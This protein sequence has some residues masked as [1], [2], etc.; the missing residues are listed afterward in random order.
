MYHAEV[1]LMALKIEHEL[2]RRELLARSRMLWEH[3]AEPARSTGAQLG[4]LSCGW[5]EVN[6]ALRC[7]WRWSRLPPCA[8]AP[9]VAA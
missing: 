2:E 4:R 7:L 6:G 8:K 3:S 5:L 9:P 1:T